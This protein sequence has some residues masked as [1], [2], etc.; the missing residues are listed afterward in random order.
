MLLSL[1]IGESKDNLK[2]MRGARKDK[3][4]EKVNAARLDKTPEDY[5][6]RRG[7]V[8]EGRKAQSKEAGQSRNWTPNLKMCRDSLPA[9]ASSSISE[10]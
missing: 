2:A 6:A 1:C 4:S 3:V 7:L 8:W 10:Y 5:K 9:R